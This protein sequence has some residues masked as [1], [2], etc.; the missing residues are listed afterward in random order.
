MGYDHGIALYN[1]MGY[2]HGISVDNMGHD[3]GISP[4]IWIMTMESTLIII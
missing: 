3:Y 2:D 4:I 1:E